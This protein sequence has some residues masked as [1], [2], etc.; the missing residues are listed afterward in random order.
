[1]RA[2]DMLRASVFDRMEPQ[3]GVIVTKA[4]KIAPLKGRATKQ[5]MKGLRP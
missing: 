1:V 5:R 3:P 2:A 4:E